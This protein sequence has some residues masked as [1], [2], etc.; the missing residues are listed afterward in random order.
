MLIFG[1]IKFFGYKTLKIPKVIIIPV[2]IP[3]FWSLLGIKPQKSPKLKSAPSPKYPQFFL[4]IFGDK[5]PKNPD[6][7]PNSVPKKSPMF[8]HAM[9]PSP[10]RP[11]KFGDG[12]GKTGDWGPVSHHYSW[13]FLLLF[14]SS[15]YMCTEVKLK[16]S[17]GLE[18][19]HCTIIVLKSSHP[20]IR[21]AD[22]WDTDFF[23]FHNVLGRNM[24]LKISRISNFIPPRYNFLYGHPFIHSFVKGCSTLAWFFQ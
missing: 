12:A 8:L 24:T 11:R 10:P 23:S 22:F 18:N 20:S 13:R 3:E 2:P 9:S 16:L 14:Y 6:F 4:G 5:T 21:C 1:I 19:Q 17:F 15:T 7:Q